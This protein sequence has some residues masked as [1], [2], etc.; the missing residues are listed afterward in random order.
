MT[1]AVPPSVLVIF[2][3]SGDLAHRYLLPALTQIS[4][5]KKLADNFQILGVSRRALKVAD[6]L[7]GAEQVLTPQT[8]MLQMDPGATADYQKLKK[9]LAAKT[10]QLGTNAQIIFY[11]AVPP[12]STLPIIEQLGAAGLNGPD[13]KLLL[14]KPFGTDLASAKELIAATAQ[15]FPQKQVYRI[16]HYLAKEMAQNIVVFLGSNALFRDVWRNQFIDEI[17]IVV[18]EQIGIEGR[19]SFYEGLGALRDMIQ[20]HALQL[21]ALTLMEPCH[22]L[23][24][25]DE[26]PA[27]RLAALR[28]LGLADD[29]P[30]VRAQYAGYRDEVGRPDSTTETFAALMLKSNDP[31]WQ[32]VPIRLITGKNLNQRLTEIRIHFK[33]TRD[34]EADRLILRIQPRE[35]IELDLWVKQPGYERELQ[36]LPLHFTYGEHFEHLPNAY[37]MVLVDAMRDNRSLFASNDEVLVSWQILEPLLKRWSK[38]AHDLKFYKPGSELSRLFD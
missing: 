27:H 18:A 9:Q 16:D 36:K 37:E 26:I 21:A 33:K 10:K 22:D 17:E 3:I 24:D 20:S 5:H 15:H 28:Q 38:D 19:A 25:F 6:V 23:F 34:S 12:E 1:G 14:E 32:G 8:A 35:A 11:F 29:P 30:A 4:A 2:G 31:R 7:G 13:T